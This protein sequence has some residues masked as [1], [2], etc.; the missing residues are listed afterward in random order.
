VAADEDSYTVGSYLLQ[1]MWE[2]PSARLDEFRSWYEEEHL[3]D[4]AAVPGILSARRF[5]RDP[6]YP[7][8][9]PTARDHLT[10]YEVADLATL[11]TPAYLRLSRTPSRRTMETAAGLGMARTVYRQLFPSRGVL[12]GAGVSGAPRQEA[13]AAVLHIMMGCQP[14]AE[15]EFNGWYNDEHLPLITGVEGVLHGRRFAVV[16]GAAPSPPGSSEAPYL[17]VYELAD[18]DVAAGPGMVAAGRPTPW[19]QRLG[20][21]VH[22]HVQVYRQ[23]ARL[24]GTGPAVAGPS[25]D[26]F[27]PGD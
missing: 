3:A 19:R 12:T 16:D 26:R 5:E 18:A 7:F 21:Q 10:L 25:G 6:S 20:D 17:A 1:L 14:V 11:S 23:V 8:A 9:H 4:M 15:Y 13:G 22:A 27:R 24:E 2:V